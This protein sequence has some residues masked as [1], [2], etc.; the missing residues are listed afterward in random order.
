MR[1][2]T[3]HAANAE[4]VPNGIAE[5]CSLL[6]L[7]QSQR[8]QVFIRTIIV[9]RPARFIIR[10]TLRNED[11]EPLP[12]PGEED[13][14]GVLQIFL[15]LLLMNTGPAGASKSIIAKC[16]VS[17][18]KIRIPRQQSIINFQTLNFEFRSRDFEIVRGVHMLF[19]IQKPPYMINL[20]GHPNTK[21]P[22]AL[23]L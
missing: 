9:F 10:I 12:G 7:S 23:P 16:S 8:L 21:R 3:T 2:I 18:T 4:R 1:K 5:K 11:D 13:A 22:D 15:S 20:S 6:N 19:P 14:I 17:I